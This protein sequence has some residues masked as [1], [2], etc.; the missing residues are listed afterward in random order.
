MDSATKT[1]KEF[2]KT[3][4]KNVIQKS[5]EATEDLVGNKTADKITSTGKPRSKKEKDEDNVM[6]GTQEKRRKWKKRENK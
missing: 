3:A 5:A 2:P 1:S 6:E 4:G